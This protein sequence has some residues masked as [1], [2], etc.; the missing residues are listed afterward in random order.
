MPVQKCL[1]VSLKS[2][3]DSVPYGGDVW[4]YFKAEGGDEEEC[5]KYCAAQDHAG[6]AV[7]VPE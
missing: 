3:F 4:W 6:K 2:F 7:D 5:Y 1:A